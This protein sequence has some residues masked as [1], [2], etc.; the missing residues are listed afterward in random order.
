MRYHVHKNRKNERA[1][2]LPAWR[3]ENLF[4][5]SEFPTNGR[6]WL[7]T[8]PKQWLSNHSLTLLLIQQNNNCWYFLVTHITWWRASVTQAAQPSALRI[9]CPGAV[10]A[11]QAFTAADRPWKPHNWLWMSLQ[12]NNTRLL[13]LNSPSHRSCRNRCFYGFSTDR[14]SWSVPEPVSAC[15]EELVAS[16][17][18]CWPTRGSAGLQL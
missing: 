18:V 15:G 12:E 8:K 16:W 6:N 4:L 14:W 5:S 9:P 3:H 11:I 1:T 2:V 17:A 10:L 13:C 7:F